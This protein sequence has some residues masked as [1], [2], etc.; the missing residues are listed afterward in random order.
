MGYLLYIPYYVILGLKF[1]QKSY[2]KKIQMEKIIINVLVV[3][4]N[5]PKAKLLASELFKLEPFVKKNVEIKINVELDKDLIHLSSYEKKA[6]DLVI[7]FSPYEVVMQNY[8][9]Y[10]EKKWPLILETNGTNYD[11]LISQLR[12]DKKINTL[13]GNDLSFSGIIYEDLIS[14]IKSKKYFHDRLME[15]IF[16]QENVFL[17]HNFYKEDINQ[18]ISCISKKKG[19]AK[20]ITNGYIDCIT[21]LHERICSTGELF[22]IKDM[23]EKEG[24]ITY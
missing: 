2:L 22:S 5:N 8:N 7:D 19:G 24:S 18:T 6:F 13:I 3:G 12:I 21:F 11:L 9:V 1:I 4:Y 20:N 23:V 14:N 17:H 10:K 15:D 16:D